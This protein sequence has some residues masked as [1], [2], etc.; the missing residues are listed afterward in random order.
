MCVTLSVAKLVKTILYAAELD[1][2]R[3]TV[4]VLGYQNN[5]QNLS[6]SD[7]SVGNA[8]ILPFPAIP[9]T[10][11]RANVISTKDCP[12]I[13]NDMVLSLESYWDA[14]NADT[15]C[16]RRRSVSTVEVFD[17]GIYTIILAQDARQIPEALAQV[18]EGKRPALNTP[19]FETYARWY[20]NW[21]LALCCFNNRDAAHATPMLW[22]YEPAYWHQLWAP[23]LDCHTGAIPDLDANVSVDHFVVFG[24]LFARS[25]MGARVRFRDKVPPS[26]APY[27]T[28]RIWGAACHDVLLPNGDFICS[29]TDLRMGNFATRVER[30]NPPGAIPKNR[31]FNRRIPVDFQRLTR[32]C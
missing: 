27:L 22:W 31:W 7:V 14:E 29:T 10:M 1:V 23:A 15:L 24:T 8:M 2:G 4:H 20:P 32:P 30:V 17:E 26:V 28:E 11:T 16:A 18:P 12:N 5:V 19:L 6:T 25:E 3:T 21:P 9:G 13:L